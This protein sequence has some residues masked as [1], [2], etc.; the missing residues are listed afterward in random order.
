MGAVVGAVVSSAVTIGVSLAKKQDID[1]KKVGVSALSGAVSGAFS[2]AGL[3][4]VGGALGST[5]DSL[6]DTKVAY[7]K[8]KNTQQDFSWGAELTKAAINI[9][10]G[11]AFG[12]VGSGTKAEFIKGCKISNEGMRGIGTLAK[13]A[14]GS[15]TRPGLTNAAKKAVTKMG[16]YCWQ[17][18]K[19]ETAGG[20]ISAAANLAVSIKIEVTFNR[21]CA[22]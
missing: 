15:T 14:L 4:A 9:G 20:F 7:D 2:A 16:R 19:G 22:L 3:G 11:A 21:L 6:Y 5:I 8:A 18:L 12:A 10:V 1:W 17:T 13:R